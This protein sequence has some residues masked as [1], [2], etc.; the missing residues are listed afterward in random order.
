MAFRGGGESLV[1]AVFWP[2]RALLCAEDAGAG[3]W[4]A[5]ALRAAR[6]ACF[7]PPRAKPESRGSLGGGG[8]GVLCWG[9]V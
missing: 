6:S 5:S 3:S 8:R 9:L 7:A 4:W 1:L 2:Q